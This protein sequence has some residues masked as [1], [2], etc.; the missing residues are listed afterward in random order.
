M[1]LLKTLM[2]LLPIIIAIGDTI[3]EETIYI[4]RAVHIQ[5]VMNNI[6]SIDYKY[7]RSIQKLDSL[8][9]NK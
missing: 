5:Q 3:K 6:D 8:I 2:I 7:N 1:F 9:N 4:T